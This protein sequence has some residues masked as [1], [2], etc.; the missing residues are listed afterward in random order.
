VTAHELL[1]EFNRAMKNKPCN[2]LGQFVK[3]QWTITAP[4]SGHQV[5]DKYA[6]FLAAQGAA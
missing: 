3:G 5:M 4:C 1:D 6:A 2:C